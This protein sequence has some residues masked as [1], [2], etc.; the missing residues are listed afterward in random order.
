LIVGILAFVAWQLTG[1]DAWVIEF[2]RVPAALLMVF[3]GLFELWLSLAVVRHFA[4]DDLL[5]PGWTLISCS[6]GCQFV[7]MI[8]SQVL[9]VRS[10]VNPLST[11]SDAGDFLIPSMRSI[12]LL[13][14]GTFRFALLAAGLHFA[15]KAYRQSGLLGRLGRADW[16]VFGGFG[17]FIVRN[18]VDVLVAVRHGKT[19]DVWEALGW[20]VDP[21]LL[22]LLLQAFLLLRSTREMGNG[23]IGLCWKAFSAGI[24]LTA[25]G[26]IGI[27]AT[28][29][30]YMPWP[31][32]ALNWYVW[33]P[34]AAAFARAPAFQLEV[35]RNV[36]TAAGPFLSEMLRSSQP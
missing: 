27:W 23:R 17:F 5:R 14:G 8:C 30:G 36:R 2:F 20:P 34:A 10:R 4:T 9:G 33:L 32:S 25:L 15:L 16:V 21:L 1:N 13:I 28:N 35:T 24:F 22:L 18:V 3:L 29:Y 19:P 7:G 6:A 26:D 11:F 12:G 31:W